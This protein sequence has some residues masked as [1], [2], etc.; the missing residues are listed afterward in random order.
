[1]TKQAE[2]P[3]TGTVAVR[4]QEQLGGAQDLLLGLAMGIFA[5]SDRTR[6]WTCQVQDCTSTGNNMALPTTG[7][8]RHVD[9]SINSSMSASR[10]AH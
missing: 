6:R 10:G 8:T 2:T 4:R 9:R 1:M 3:E 5:S 7:S